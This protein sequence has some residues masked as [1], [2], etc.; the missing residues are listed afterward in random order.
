MDIFVHF[1][2]VFCYKCACI[3]ANCIN[4]GSGVYFYWNFNISPSFPSK[5]S[6]LPSIQKNTHTQDLKD[7]NVPIETH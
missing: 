3:N 6:I 2:L 5:K 1:S 4:F 7:K